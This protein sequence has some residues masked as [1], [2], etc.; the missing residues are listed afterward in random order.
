MSYNAFAKIE[1]MNEKLPLVSIIVPVYNVEKYLRQCLDSLISQTLQNIEIICVNDASPDNSLAILKQ[2]EAKDK[3]IIVIDLKENLC[4]GGARNVGI[5]YARGEYIAFIDSD[6]WVTY[7]M[8]EILYMSVLEEDADIVICDYYEYRGVDNIKKYIKY[9]SCIFNRPKEEANKE[10]ILKLSATWHNL[11]KK[12]IFINNDI[13]FPEHT[14]YEDAAIIPTIMLLAD[15]V[16]KV[17]KALYYYRLDNVSITRQKNNYRFFEKRNAAKYFLQNMKRFSF[18]EKYK[19]E[20]DFQYNNLYYLSII[21]G[22]LIY[23]NP[24][25]RR[26]IIKIRNEISLEIPE[27]KNNPYYNS[28]RFSVRDLIIDTIL[29]NVNLG[30]LLFLLFRLCLFVRKLFR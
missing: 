10:F 6:D 24:I 1:M 2:Y 28:C 30:V 27:Y 12:S 11:Y 25:D 5:K 21:W 16:V 29:F 19:N 17:D 15:K 20:I 22:C 4:L 26:S 23:F 9:R 18:Y 3:R 14:F 8:C 13:W 7:D